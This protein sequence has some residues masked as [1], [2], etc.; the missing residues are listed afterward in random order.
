MKARITKR[1][2]REALQ[3]EYTL[4]LHTMYLVTLEAEASDP[5]VD[6]NAARSMINHLLIAAQAIFDSGEYELTVVNDPSV[7]I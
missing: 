4:N 1:F 5:F 3:W 2:D 7:D 6:D